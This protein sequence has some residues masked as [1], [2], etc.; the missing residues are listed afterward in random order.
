MLH[1]TSRHGGLGALALTLSA[2][3]LLAGP[4]QA[5]EPM[6]RF[7]ISATATWVDPVFPETTVVSYGGDGTSGV[8]VRWGPGAAVAPSG[9]DILGLGPGQIDVI[10][11]MSIPYNVALFRH[12][13]GAAEPAG[14]TGITL[15]LVTQIASPSGRVFVVLLPF[16]FRH[17]ETGNGLSPC[18]YG[19]ANGQGINSAG[20]ADRVSSD[21][22]GLLRV[23]SDD[24]AGQTYR[25]MFRGF[26][27]HQGGIFLT[28]EGAISTAPLLQVTIETAP[29]AAVPEPG[30]WAMLIVGF[31]LV[32][33][34]AR[35]RAAL[36]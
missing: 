3:L 19:G 22:N 34:A 36:A 12:V 16:V 32:G 8:S 28:S 11:S 23:L 18:P 9:Y 14:I 35:R 25:I 20:C 1:D 21:T 17:D 10:G 29:G 30:S 26:P 15:N 6:T 5:A 2:A 33:A 24:V 31:G 27:A 7:D 4:A 13:N